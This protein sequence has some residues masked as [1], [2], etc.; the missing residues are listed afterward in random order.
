MYVD[1]LLLSG[2]M[3]NNN[4]KIINSQTAGVSFT[5]SFKHINIIFLYG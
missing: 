2:A 3:Y 1:D 5:G 4:N